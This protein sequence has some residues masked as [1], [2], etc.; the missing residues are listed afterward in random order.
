MFGLFTGRI[1]RLFAKLNHCEFTAR[2]DVDDR[3]SPA[4]FLVADGGMPLIILII[5]IE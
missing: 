3:K 4:I 1:Q 2:V 5:R